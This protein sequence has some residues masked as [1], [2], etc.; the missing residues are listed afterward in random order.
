MTDKEKNEKQSLLIELAEC[1]KRIEEINKSR[2]QIFVRL[3]ELVCPFQIGDIT[4]C[5]GYT[6]RGKRMRVDSRI[7]QRSDHGNY[8]WLVSGRVIKRNGA[9]SN[10][11]A[12]FTMMDYRFAKEI[13]IKGRPK[14]FKL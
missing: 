3:L 1:D 5:V 11:T 7:V 9:G 13:E 6:H 8:Y 2:E 12:E 14:E 4:E 10:Y